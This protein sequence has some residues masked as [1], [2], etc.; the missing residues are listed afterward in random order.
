MAETNP[1]H[2]DDLTDE[3]DTRRQIILGI[4]DRPR[5]DQDRLRQAG[6]RVMHQ[7]LPEGMIPFV[8]AEYFNWRLDR[9]LWVHECKHHS[10]R[11]KH[12]LL[13]C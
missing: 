11:N 6:R 7:L 13:F 5:S 8:S 9:Y 10:Y 12:L 3:E 4:M 1:W 2:R